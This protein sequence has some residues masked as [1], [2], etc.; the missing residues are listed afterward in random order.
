[1]NSVE[2][3]VHG[4]RGIVQVTT[5]RAKQMRNRPLEKSLPAEVCLKPRDSISGLGFELH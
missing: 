2:K 3:E 1:M 4:K 5:E